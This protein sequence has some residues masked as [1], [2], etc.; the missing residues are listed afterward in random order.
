MICETDEHIKETLIDSQPLSIDML[1]SMGWKLV[2]TFLSTQ[3]YRNDLYED[4]EITAVAYLGAFGESYFMFELRIPW[5][6]RLSGCAIVP[7]I[8]YGELRKRLEKV[9]NNDN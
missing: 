6:D 2:H 7:I 8:N 1:K 9:Y 5:P 3:Y 4:T